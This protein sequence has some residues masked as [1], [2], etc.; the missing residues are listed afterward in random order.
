M[1]WFSANDAFVFGANDGLY[2]ATITNTSTSMLTLAGLTAKPEIRPTAAPILA[3]NPVQRAFAI[4]TG[5]PTNDVGIVSSPRLY[6]D[7]AQA[8]GKN[9]FMRFGIKQSK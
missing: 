7:I 4:V 8:T 2:V 1:G 3:N 6:A 9:A 5:H